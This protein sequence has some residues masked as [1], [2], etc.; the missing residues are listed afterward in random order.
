MLD[1][2][3]EGTWTP[4]ISGGVVSTDGGNTYTKVGRLVTILM[5]F[6][7]TTSSTL[8]IISGLPFAT[9]TGDSKFQAAGIVI[10][11]SGTGLVT[12]RVFSNGSFIY[13]YDNSSGYTS[14]P[15]TT[16][17]SQYT[18]SFSYTTTA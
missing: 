3:E 7:V 5:R 16:S 10:T 8:N 14:H 2:Y 18:L 11:S 13:L 1:D 9:D 4:A 17:R 6:H 15:L 12:A